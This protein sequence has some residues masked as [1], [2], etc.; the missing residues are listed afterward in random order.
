MPLPLAAAIP[1]IGS[2]VGAGINAWSQ[3]RQNRRSQDFSREMYDRQYNDN[4]EFWRMQNDY[5]HPSA[6]AKRLQEAG[7]NKSLMYGNSASGG[8]A[9]PISTPDVQSAQFKSPDLGGIVTGAMQNVLA[10]QDVRIKQAQHDNLRAQNQQILESTL[11]TKANRI[12]ED[13]QR[14][15]KTKQITTDVADKIQSGS[16]RVNQNTRENQRINNET[17]KLEADLKSAVLRDENLKMNTKAASAR[18]DQILK[19]TEY[20]QLKKEMLEMGV[21]TSDPLFVRIIQQIISQSLN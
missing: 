5:N 16:L 2:V 8:N 15:I 1:A 21:N 4:L 13:S 9:G 3:G 10:Y 19:S 20:L 7:L 17:R 14:G 11:L 12:T 6:Q 18:I